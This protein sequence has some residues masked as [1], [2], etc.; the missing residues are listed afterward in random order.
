MKLAYTVRAFQYL[1]FTRP[2]IS[3]AIQQI[4]LFMHNPMDDHIHALRRIL[5]YIQGT[6]HFGIHLYPS[7]TTSLISYTY[8]NWGGCPDTRK[9][10]SGYCLFLSD[11]LLSWSSKCKPTLS[12]SS[13]EVKYRGV[14]NMVSESCWLRNLLLEL[15]CPVHTA[16]LVYCDNVSVI[17]LARNPI[18]HQRTKHIKMDIHFVHEKVACGQVRILHIPSCYQIVDIFTKGLPLVLF[19]DFRD[20]LSV[21]QPPTSTAGV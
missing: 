10:T 20:S 16:T 4:Y 5:C 9:S 12:C 3:Y 19:Q 2:D 1:I 7:L 6:L 17:Y 11:N 14:A 13:A 15:H 21:R 8:A 18:Q